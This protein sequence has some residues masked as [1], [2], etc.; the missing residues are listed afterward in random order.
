MTGRSASAVFAPTRSHVRFSSG[1]YL[2]DAKCTEGMGEGAE[3]QMDPSERMTQSNEDYL[4]AVYELS[5]G[6][7]N[8][9]RSVDIAE[10]LGVSKA[11]VNK[12]VSVLRDNGYVDQEPYGDVFITDKGLE[13]GHSV[14]ERHQVLFHFLTDVLGVDPDTAEHE[15]CSMEHSIS[16]DTLSKWIDFLE[17]NMPDAAR[18]ADEDASF[19]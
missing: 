19:E 3:P 14:F 2:S 9:V 18:A 1:I 6:K 16:D 12:A 8:P 10:K 15:A 11:S 7:P 4:E 5:N 17:T 13:Y